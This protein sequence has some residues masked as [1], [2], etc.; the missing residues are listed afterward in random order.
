MTPQGVEQGL[1]LR[2]GGSVAFEAGDHALGISRQRKPR[3]VAGLRDPN[4]GEGLFTPKHRIP[5]CALSV[6]R[7]A[8]GSLVQPCVRRATYLAGPRRYQPVRFRS[9]HRRLGCKGS[10]EPRHD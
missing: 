8:V 6:V 9:R 10:I 3:A 4:P 7:Q 5:A 1:G 2:V